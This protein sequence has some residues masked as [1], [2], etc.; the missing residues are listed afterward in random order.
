MA[1]TKLTPIERFNANIKWIGNCLI[2]Q[3]T[4]NGLA[5]YGQIRVDGKRTLVHRY[6]YELLVEPIPEGLYVCHTCDN[7]LCVNPR[8]LFVGTQSD[9]LNDA[10]SKGR[11]NAQIDATKN[12]PRDAL[13]RFSTTKGLV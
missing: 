8:H 2:W 3:G 7:R 5:G 11:W 9:N 1:W 12:R 10:V 4:T 13:G 6:A